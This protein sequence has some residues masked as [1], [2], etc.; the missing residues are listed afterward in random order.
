MS[1]KAAVFRTLVPAPKTQSKY[2]VYIPKVSLSPILVSD[3]VFPFE[4]K[5]EYSINVGGQPIYIPGKSQVPGEWTCTITET[6]DLL[7]LASISMLEQAQFRNYVKG[8]ILTKAKNAKEAV[9][10][11]SSAQ[12]ALNIVDPAVAKSFNTTKVITVLEEL[13][14]VP[15]K[16]K[17]DL[18]AVNIIIFLTD[19]NTGLVPLSYRV[20]KGAWLKSVDAQPLDWSKPESA[21]KWKLHFR[22]QSL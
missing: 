15:Q 20:L 9:N 18:N 14:L 16:G 17:G 11:I 10:A 22:Y 21:I 7:S 4:Q 6:K 2:S 5:T 13:G 12:A 19:E 3:C 1:L 8:S